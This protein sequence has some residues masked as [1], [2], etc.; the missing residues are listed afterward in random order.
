[1]TSIY[2]FLEEI[3][4]PLVWVQTFSTEDAAS[5]S[6][7]A[8]TT[9]E[10][11]ALSEISALQKEGC[12]TTVVLSSIHA[13][14]HKISLPFLPE[15]KMRQALTYALEEELAESIEDIHLAFDK[16]R[17]VEGQQ[18]VCVLNKAYLLKVLEALQYYGIQVDCVTLDY[19]ALHT[20]EI[21]R[22]P[23]GLLL[24]HPAF[25]GFCSEQLLSLIDPS[26]LQQS[27]TIVFYDSMPI[28]YTPLHTQTITDPFFTWC[29]RRLE[30]NKFILDLRQGNIRPSSIQ[31]WKWRS[32]LWWGAGAC[33]FIWLGSILLASILQYYQLSQR[34]TILTEALFKT[35]QILAPKVAHGADPVPYLQQWLKQQ[36]D[37]LNTTWWTLL[38]KVTPALSEAS[39]HMRECRFQNKQMIILVEASQFQ[40]LAE[41][42]KQLEKTHLKVSQKKA[43]MQHGTVLATLE[44][45]P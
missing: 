33:L 25:Q 20:K 32:P 27:D 21:V 14:I 31:R 34:H 35:Q 36:E 43:N 3:E 16:H 17:Y 13:S 39:I 42:M 8:T 22:L 28:S 7:T 41:L 15:A 40:Q 29:T 45:Q 26:I 18:E 10:Q 23:E 30:S 12:R 2:V 24:R 19:M 38:E 1:M 37:T 4:T 9:L 11:L 5:T 6:T 44:I